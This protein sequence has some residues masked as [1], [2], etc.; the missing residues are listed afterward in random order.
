LRP[1]RVPVR[2]ASRWGGTA[3]ILNADF[4]GAELKRLAPK[5]TK[6]RVLP[7]D[8]ILQGSKADRLAIP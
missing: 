2:P 8:G 7:V 5:L 1:S 3:A 6:Y 4:I